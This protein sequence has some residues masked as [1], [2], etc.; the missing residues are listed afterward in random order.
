MM[1][2]EVSLSK[3]L[4]WYMFRRSNPFVDFTDNPIRDGE[5]DSA[6]SSSAKPINTLESLLK[7]LILAIVIH[8]HSPGPGTVLFLSHGLFSQTLAV[9]TSQA[10]TL[11]IYLAYHAKG[12]CDTAT[13][14][15]K[16]PHHP[17]MG[18]SV[19]QTQIR[20]VC[21]CQ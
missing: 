8:H 6:A 16:T 13:K 1:K 21:S 12:W 11:F 17:S 20:V 3:Y 2:K 4:L 9:C 14:T 7:P 19:A 18:W 15:A 5:L 10:A